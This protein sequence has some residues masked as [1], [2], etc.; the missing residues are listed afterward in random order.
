[1]YTTKFKLNL[2]IY[3]ALLQ[4]MFPVLS[5]AQKITKIDLDNADRL[6][7][8][9]NIGENV[10]R[11][12]GNV[13]LHHEGT[14]LYCDSAYLYSE[15]NSVDAFSNV[16]IKSGT[17]HIVGDVLYYNGNT[18]D[19]ELD[20]N[21]KMTDEKMEL[22]TEHLTYNTKTKIANYLTGGKLKDAENVLTSK[23]GY[24]YAETKEVYFKKEVVLVNPEYTMN[25]DTLKYNTKTEIA[26]FFGPTY[27]VSKE[28]TIYCENGW[29]NTQKDIAQFNENAYFSNKEQK[30]NGD[31]L[32]YDRKILFGKA[33]NNI[34]IIDTTQEI[35]I[36]GN[37]A[38]YYE[39]EGKTMVT[40]EA[41]VI[42]NMDGDSLFLHADTLKAFFD[43]TGAGKVLYAYNHAK[44]FKSDIQGLGDSIVYSFTDSVIYMYS[45]PILWSEENQITADTIH[46]FLKNNELYRMNLYS[47]SFIVSKEDSVK[48]N[49]IKGKF[50]I[51][52][53]FENELRKINVY[54]NSETIYYVRD[55]SKGLIGINKAIAD[56]MLIFVDNS[57]VKT[58]TFLTNPEATL[59][60]EKDLAPA[61]VK[62]KGFKWDEF[63]RPLDK[64]GVFNW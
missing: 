5:Y 54:Q 53:F 1:M 52:H 26:Y 13:I 16:S 62:L 34:T 24:Y 63:K 36:K 23:I 58:I 55:E 21:V 40:N 56:D 14:Y 27:I 22:E 44:F 37:Y 11:L 50:V 45:N 2:I 41:L 46:I 20:K 47:S 39:K 48:Y 59:Y 18:K 19:A 35:T 4:I 25:S 28:N 17:V 9:K 60:P 33:Y 43:S 8:D 31:S 32:Y 61:E 10:K 42:H 30:I 15:T 64:E 6:E 49:Q 51:G 29:Y 38:E 3:G 7:Y 12:I 57:K